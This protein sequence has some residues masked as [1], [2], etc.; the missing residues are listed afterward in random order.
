MGNYHAQFLG[1]VSYPI[2]YE[3]LQNMTELEKYIKSYF[4]VADTNDLKTIVSF[5]KLTTI[6]KG[7]FLLKANKRCDKL[8][9]VESGLLRTFTTTDTK[10]ITLWISRK[11]YF[12]ADISSFVFETVSRWAIQALVDTEVHIITKEDYNKIGTLVSNWNEFEKIFTISC[13]TV[14]EERIFSHLSMTTKE[15][16]EEY[17]Q[18]NREI[19]NQVP[20]QYIASFLGMTPETFSRIRKKQ[21]L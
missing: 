14:L 10:E 19:F 20:L 4:G 13:F 12:S 17:F 16:Y 6:K 21:S 18:N 9:F 5:F 2:F 1:G 3:T 8:C 11:G 15:R 7:D